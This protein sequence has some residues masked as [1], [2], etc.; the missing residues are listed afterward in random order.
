MTNK[1]DRRNHA[2]P[3]RRQFPVIEGYKFLQTIARSARSEV[4]VAHSVELKQ[5][6][7]VKVLRVGPARRR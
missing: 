4:Y 1:V 5:N 3:D 7:A 2:I 6:V